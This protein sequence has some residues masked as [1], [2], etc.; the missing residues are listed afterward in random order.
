MPQPNIKLAESLE[1]LRVLQKKQG[2]ALKTSEITRTHRERLVKN[3]FLKKVTKK[4]FI[5]AN[6]SNQ[7]GDSTAWYTSFW[8]FCKRY[9]EDRYDQNYCLSSEQSLLL[10]AGCTTIPHQLIVRSTDAPNKT[11]ELLYGTSL[12]IL[13]SNLIL[14]T[15]VDVGTKLRIQTKEEALINMSPLIFEQNPIEVR[16]VLASIREP[17][18]LLRLLLERSHSVKAGRL[19]GAFNNVRKN[20]IAR[21]IK[22]AMA[23]ADYTIRVIDPFLGQSPTIIDFKSVSPYVNRINLLWESMRDDVVNIFPKSTGIPKN[24]SKYLQSIEAIYTTDAYHSLSIENYKVSTELI[25]KVRSG[26]WNLEDEEDRKHRDAMAARG[27]WQSFQAVQESI[28]KLFENENSGVIFDLDH[29]EWYRQLFGPSVTVGLLT[30]SDLA[31]Y[32]NDQVYINNSMHT[33]LNRDAVRDA[34]PTL[35]DLLKKE[36]EASVRSVLGH[37]IFVYIHPYGDGNGRM[38]RF[39]MNM[40]LISGG[41]PWTVIPVERREEYMQVLEEASVNN[42]ISPFAVFISDLVRKSIIGEPEARM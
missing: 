5:I 17:S 6:P 29:G 22:K 16:T 7:E 32:R 26:K 36:K 19:I 4:W 23:A 31:G 28:K 27:Y 8:G 12:Y 18:S 30:I 34:M 39:L 40:M 10:H 1:I 37:F 33:P 24:T 35:I 20:R 38:G 9:L 14:E 3:G 25:D 15:E 42:N 21:E 11:I 41:Y 2:R 13:K